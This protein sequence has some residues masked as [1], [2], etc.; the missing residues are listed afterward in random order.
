MNS[1]FPALDASSSP[2]VFS[3]VL[4]SHRPLSLPITCLPVPFQPCGLLCETERTCP[5]RISTNGEGGGA[6]PDPL[7]LRGE[8]SVAVWKCKPALAGI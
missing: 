5:W 6:D 7:S 2:L 3:P 1:F 8:L 4:S